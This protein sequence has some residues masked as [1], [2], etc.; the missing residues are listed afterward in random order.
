MKGCEVLLGSGDGSVTCGFHEFDGL[1]NEGEKPGT[2][3]ESGCTVG[4]ALA[5]FALCASSTARAKPNVMQPIAR[6][7]N[8]TKRDKKKS[9]PTNLRIM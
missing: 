2:A 9:S 7:M 4:N 3:I 1:G 8:E 6:Q 5:F